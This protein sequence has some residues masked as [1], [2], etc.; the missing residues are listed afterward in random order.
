[1]TPEP[2]QFDRARQ[3]G[4]ELPR[5][6]ACVEKWTVHQLDIDA[7]VLRWLDCVGDLDQFAGGDV[8]IGERAGFDDFMADCRPRSR[9]LRARRL[10]IGVQ[11]LQADPPA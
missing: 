6:C 1:V 10:S 5:C 8:G 2:S 9:S 11:I 7:A 3:R 4:A